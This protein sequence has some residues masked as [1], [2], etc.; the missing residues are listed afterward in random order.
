MGG[1]CQAA[2][3]RTK[4]GDR[5][6][7]ALHAQSCH[8]QSPD[9]ICGKSASNFLVERLSTWRCAKGNDNRRNRV[10][11]AFLPAYFAFQVRKN[12]ALRHSIQS[13]QSKAARRTIYDGHSGG[14]QAQ[15]LVAGSVQAEAELRPGALPTLPSGTFPYCKQL[16]RTRTTTTN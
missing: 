1:V 15:T 3:F 16:E 10:S 8:F 6:P 13:Q 7:G 14:N 12:Q 4:T 9:K 2:V 11:A 5:I